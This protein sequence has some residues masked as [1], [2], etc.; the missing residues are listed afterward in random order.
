MND[1]L[2]KGRVYDLQTIGKVK[3]LTFGAS[4]AIVQ[5]MTLEDH[6]TISVRDLRKVIG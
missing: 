2:V 6:I 1:E 5:A 4:R 3:V